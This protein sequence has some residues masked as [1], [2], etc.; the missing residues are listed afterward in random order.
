[1]LVIFMVNRDAYTISANDVIGVLREF[2]R[3][4]ERTGRQGSLFAFASQLTGISVDSLGQ[5][6]YEE[7]MLDFGKVVFRDFDDSGLPVEFFFDYEAPKEQREAFVSG[8]GYRTD[9]CEKVSFCLS[10]ASLDDVL[11]EA[12]LKFDDGEERRVELDFTKGIIE[13]LIGVTERT[14]TK[15]GLEAL[16]S[17]QEFVDDNL[18]EICE[19]SDRSINRDK[20]RQYLED[21]MILEFSSP[22]ECMDYFNTCD[23]QHF[24]SVAEMKRYQGMFG[25]G[26]DGK[27]YHISFREA[28]A[29]WEPLSFADKLE[30]AI[31]ECHYYSSSNEKS[32]VYEKA[33]GYSKRDGYTV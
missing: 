15:H 24:R 10:F 16:N 8:L 1:M 32:V 26:L 6:I 22:E 9:I 11:F 21:E 29:V 20:L 18:G 5:E 31:R 27:W 4:Y 23:S 13:E 19:G 28:L 7:Y 14:R 2:V 25:F 33:E 3:E 12:L 17:L 30:N